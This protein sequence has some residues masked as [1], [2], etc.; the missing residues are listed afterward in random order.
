MTRVYS[1]QKYKYSDTECFNLVCSVSNKDIFVFTAMISENRVYNMVSTILDY[2]EHKDIPLPM[3]LHE[4]RV[5]VSALEM[6]VA[7]YTCEWLNS[8]TSP[9]DFSI[10]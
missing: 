3:F 8:R 5:F 10:F 6:F 2:H 4:Q 1:D 9:D 7:G